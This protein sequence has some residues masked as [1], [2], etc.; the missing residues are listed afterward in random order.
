MQ[1]R[2]RF[3]AYELRNTIKPIFL[4]SLFCVFFVSLGNILDHYCVIAYKY[5]IYS[6]MLSQYNTDAILTT[7][8]RATV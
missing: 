4:F 2:K 6:V 8:Q 3:A 7:N 1:P 5:T